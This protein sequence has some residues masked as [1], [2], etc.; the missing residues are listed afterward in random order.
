MKFEFFCFCFRERS[1][2]PRGKSIKKSKD[3]VKE[4]KDRKRRQGK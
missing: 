4:K 3:W 2:V 1:K